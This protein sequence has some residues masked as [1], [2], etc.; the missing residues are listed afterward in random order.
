MGSPG[1]AYDA[2]NVEIVLEELGA[3][4]V[5]HGEYMS[6]L[7]TWLPSAEEWAPLE[8]CLEDAV[9]RQQE[10]RSV[11][12]SVYRLASDAIPVVNPARAHRACRLVPNLLRRLADEGIPICPFVSGNDLEQIAHF[13]DRHANH[14]CRARRLGTPSWREFPVDLDYLRDHHLEFDE[15]PLVVRETRGC[16]SLHLLVVGGRCAGA[17]TWD[18]VA[19]G[20]LPEPSPA[21]AIQQMAIG[22]A[23]AGGLHLALVHIEE[24]TALQVAGLDPEPDLARLEDEARVPAIDTVADHLVLLA[25]RMPAHHASSVATHHASSVATHHAS[26]SVATHHASSVA[27]RPAAACARTALRIGITGLGSNDEVAALESAVQARG[28]QPVILEFPWFPSERA[29]HECDSG[30]RI[31]LDALAELDAVFVRST[32]APSPV[33]SILSEVDVPWPERRARFGQLAE[34]RE[35]CFVFQYAVL[36]LLGRRV[37]VINP[38]IAQEVHRTK[39][40]QL[41]SLMRAGFPV[42][43]TLAGNAPDA[44]A[45]F[46]AEQGGPE[47]VVVKPLAGIYKTT[48][49]SERGLQSALASGPVILQR[50]IRGDTIRA[51][52][53]G[54]RLIGAAKSLCI[55]GAIDSSVGQYGVQVVELPDE[56]AALGWAA[57][58]HLGLS[59]TGMDFMHDVATDQYFIL[60]CNAAAMFANFS[61]MTGFDVAGA[62]ADDLIERA[63]QTRQRGRPA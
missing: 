29:L 8:S 45:R 28:H 60:E 25:S 6:P 18:A 3:L 31:A 9:R 33:E 39:V 34:A 49:L 14:G 35:E 52:F 20:W 47:H 16:R 55:G 59:W 38:P 27:A 54:G 5:A 26:S 32:G 13:V 7:P 22:A 12:A 17:S 62:L 24:G 19:N 4:Y 53:A 36:E 10:A 1:R 50:Y 43:P 15:F 40:H 41:F 56:I 63:S 61:A 44:C 42:P 57:A 23:R 46:V 48:L 51:Y 11:R 30:G 2:R 37:P 58:Q 21:N